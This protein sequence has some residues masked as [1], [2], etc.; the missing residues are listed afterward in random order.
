MT[1]FACIGMPMRLGMQNYKFSAHLSDFAKKVGRLYR[2]GTIFTVAYY[3]TVS[4]PT[5]EILTICQK[6]KK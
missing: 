3:K 2:Y 5:P 6:C 1:G 4:C